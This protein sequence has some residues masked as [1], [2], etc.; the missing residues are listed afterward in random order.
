[1]SERNPGADRPRRDPYPPPDPW[2]STERS[3]FGRP[4]TPYEPNGDTYRPEPTAEYPSPYTTVPGQ[5]AKPYGQPEPT[6]PVR[7]RDP[8]RPPRDRRARRDDRHPSPARGTGRGLPVGAGFLVGVAGLVAF[9]LALLGLPWFEAGGQ[10]VTLSDIRTAF[11]I[12]ET[13]PDD[14]LGDSTDQPPPDDGGVPTA[15]E[16]SEAVEQEVRE[17]ASEAAAAAI[18]TGKARYL[19]LYVDLLWGLVAAAV[20]LAV[21][22]STIVTPRSTAGSL[23]F[24]L[25]PLAGFVTVVAG[26]VHGA[27]LWVVFSGDGA[28]DPALGVWLG[29]AGLGAVLLACIVGP[30]R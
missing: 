12:P 26:A 6:R 24:P 21:V 30:K 22:F 1:M 14:L 28:P 7:R 3:V 19:E 23:L 10:D 16:V 20:V 8:Q 4:A 13:D 9:L 17:T 25:R 29:I 18:D 5:P 2:E 27:A 11:T 15:D